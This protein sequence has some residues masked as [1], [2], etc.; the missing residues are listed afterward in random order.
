MSN[1]PF[2]AQEMSRR[3]ALRLGGAIGLSAALA[4]FLG[5]CSPGSSS[6]GAG[7]LTF[8]N[9]W[10]DP[11]SKK[12]AETLFA[13]FTKASG[14][15]IGNQTQPN[16]GSTYQPAI[17]NAFSSG[18]PPSLATTISGPEVYSLARA[19]VLLDLT[20]FYDSTLKS[21]AQAGATAG[22]K[23]DGKVWG[24]S[25]GANVGNCVWYN[26]DYLS[27]YNVSVD[28]IVDVDSWI[29]AMSSI[30][31]AGG[32]PIVLG[33][34]DQWPGGHYLNDLVQRRLGS[35]NATALYNRTVIANAPN[36][37]KW[38]DD[39]VVAS[40]EDYVK[41]KP[42]F[43]DGFLGEAAATTDGQFLGGRVGFYEMGSW[44]LSGMREKPP[45]FTT[46]VMLFPSVAGGDGTG[47]EVTLGNETIIASHDAD[48]DA[49]EAFFSFF[50]KPKSLAEWAGNQFT[51]PP[52][53]YDTNE[54][55]ID[56]PV[57]KSLFAD[58]NRFSADSGPGGAALFNDQA[59]DVNIYTKYI[60]QGSVGLMSGDVAPEQLAQQLENATVKA[61]KVL[62]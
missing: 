54:V 19:G 33:A 31:S 2:T 28:D 10:S 46:G 39:Q 36:R 20:D 29:A 4:P 34:K 26:E 17:R 24:L 56:D 21:R 42:L 59:I 30:K 43:P 52:Y 32:V 14:I 12:N 50:V 41:F 22:S 40:F 25:S 1:T 37:V 9:R 53:N 18:S 16:S 6:G 7:K 27:K 61:Q 49:V 57:L 8:M 51:T 47:K 44:F 13:A 45:S 3:S 48:A 15:K 62:S 23:L 58:V 5:A 55:K 35:A 60:W 38:T 11:T